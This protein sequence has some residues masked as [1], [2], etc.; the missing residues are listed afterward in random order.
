MVSTKLL[1]DSDD[2]TSTESAAMTLKKTKIAMTNNERECNDDFPTVERDPEQMLG[3]RLAAFLRQRGYW[4]LSVH[5]ASEYVDLQ[6]VQQPV[7]P[8]SE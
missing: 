8:P 4:H 3:L 1:Q 2:P 7:H 6:L 5:T